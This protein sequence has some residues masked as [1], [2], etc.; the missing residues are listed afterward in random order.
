MKRI[1]GTVCST[2]ALLFIV[3]TGRRG[4]H[5]GPPR[6]EEDGTSPLNACTRIDSNVRK[7]SPSE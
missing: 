2:I 6:S 1:P 7:V 3:T 5:S 4:N